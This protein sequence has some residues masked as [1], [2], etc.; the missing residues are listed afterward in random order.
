MKAAAD[1]ERVIAVSRSWLGTPYHD[2]ASLPLPRDQPMKHLLGVGH[3]L[4]DRALSESAI[5]QVYLARLDGLGNPMLVAQS[6]DE[7]TGTGATIHRVV[8]GVE[9]FPDGKLVTLRDWEVLLNMNKLNVPTNA[10]LPPSESELAALAELMDRLAEAI[11]P[12]ALPF[13]RPKMTAVLAMLPCA[14][15]EP[16]SVAGEHSVALV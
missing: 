13:R 2:Q 16:G 10:P 15:A 3:P 9:I 1:P 5:G 11:K 7:L 6:E 8:F 12:L 14:R 4:I